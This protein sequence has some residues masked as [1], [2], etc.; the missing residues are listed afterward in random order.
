MRR[1]NDETIWIDVEQVTE[2][3]L[4]WLLEIEGEQVWIPKSQV[5]GKAR[6]ADGPFKGRLRRVEI[7][8][9]MAKLKGLM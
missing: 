6:H 7:R 2:T 4:A 9:W 8:Q 1:E 3:E 5:R